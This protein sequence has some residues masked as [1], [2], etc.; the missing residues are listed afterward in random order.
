MN[1]TD[2]FKTTGQCFCAL[3]VAGSASWLAGCAVSQSAV[4]TAAVQ[5]TKVVVPL[6]LFAENKMQVIKVPGW[7]YNL[8][9]VQQPDQQYKALLMRCTH[10]GYQ[11][12][13]E[14][15]GLHCNQHGSSFNLNGEVTKGPAAEPLKHFPVSIKDQQLLIG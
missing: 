7:Q 10:R 8:L 13:A 9:V 1:R 12:T 15:N 3:V 6:S 11:L 4:Y 2:F 5:Q 14:K